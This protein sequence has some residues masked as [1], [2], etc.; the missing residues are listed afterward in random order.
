MDT[1][2]THVHLLFMWPYYLYKKQFLWPHCCI[3]TIGRCDFMMVLYDLSTHCTTKIYFPWWLV[4][5]SM[6]VQTVVYRR[7]LFQPRWMV[8]SLTIKVLMILWYH[9]YA[10]KN[11]QCM[12]TTQAYRYWQKWCYRKHSQQYLS[13]MYTY[14]LW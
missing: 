5:C 11:E 3:G 7:H 4:W 12:W 13:I 6:Y 1:K 8:H 14:C 9:Y 10:Y 2:K